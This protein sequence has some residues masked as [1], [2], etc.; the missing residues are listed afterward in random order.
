M[1]PR[2]LML[3][4]S[5]LMVT[6]CTITKVDDN[7]IDG[8]INTILN[9]KTE[10]TNTYSLG[11]QYYLPRNVKVSS[12]SDYNEML[13]TNNINYYLYV[14]VISYYHK[15]NISY[16]EYKKAYYSKMLEFN[17]KKGYI[18]INKINDKYF[19][20]MMFNYAKIE[21]Y[22]NKDYLSQAIID[23]CYILSNLTYNE[24]IIK[25]LIDNDDFDKG[26][27]QFNIFKP[28]REEGK[29]L[30]YIK[31]YDKYEDINNQLP[32]YE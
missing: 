14:D 31:E 5:L 11:Y 18:E 3:V 9:N 17:D 29:Y 12:I 32:D 7:N 1:K 25:N 24:K 30:D 19:I 13:Y 6:G 8:I 4:I 10:V 27:E 20:E 28:K 16:N 22:V 2:W 26:A 15:V 23:G 21:S